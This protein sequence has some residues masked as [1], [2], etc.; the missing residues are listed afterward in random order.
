MTAT[1]E[2]LC[3]PGAC[4]DCDKVP[5]ATHSGEME[6][7]GLKLK[8]HKLDNGQTVVDADDFKR[9]LEWMASK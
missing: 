3:A 2:P 8:V 6:F 5:T 9:L 7:G 4:L 1:H